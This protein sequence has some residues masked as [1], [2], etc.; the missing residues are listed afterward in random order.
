MMQEGST[1]FF[2]DCG[3]P[4]HAI[5]MMLDG[6]GDDAVLMVTLW[7]DP[8]TL[9]DRIA[10][11]WHALVGRP[12]CFG[13][14]CLRGESLRAFIAYVSNLRW[15]THATITVSDGSIYRFVNGQWT[16]DKGGIS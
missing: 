11:A 4:G 16:Q 10:S 9:K 12:R 13:E 5:D 15:P 2:C 8:P 3:V 7:H 14:V 1:L 6:E